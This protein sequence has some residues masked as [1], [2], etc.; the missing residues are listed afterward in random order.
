[1]KK[2]TKTKKIEIIVFAVVLFVMV[3]SLFWAIFNIF[4]APLNY[5]DDV[6][7]IK[8]DYALMAMEAL[9][10]ILLLFLPTI[11]EKKFRFDIPS[12]MQIFVV[13]FLFAAVF[14][15]EFR[16][17]HF[18]VPYWDKILHLISG[19]FLA[20]LGFSIIQT[21][22]KYDIIYM[23]PFFVALFSFSFAMTIGSLWEIY[24]YFWDV[25]FNLNMLKYMDENGVSYVGIHALSDTLTDLIVDAIGAFIM[26][27]IGY[28]AVKLNKTW[29]YEFIIYKENKKIES[30]V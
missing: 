2:T 1:M 3:L 29:I 9:G 28:V 23:N 19:A 5:S 26:S 13:I 27:A 7:L 22:N 11:L 24:E 15:G 14:L 6:V 8:N 4:K 25:N 10:A 17:F 18:V 12:L 30:Q 16:R 21:F 20:S